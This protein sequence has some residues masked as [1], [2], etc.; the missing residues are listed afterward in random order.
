MNASKMTRKMRQL[1][2]TETKHMLIKKRL[3]NLIWILTL[4]M[5]KVTSKEARIKYYY[6]R[7]TKLVVISDNSYV[8]YIC[9]FL[10]TAFS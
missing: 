8:E 7:P 9:F 1:K 5:L 10:L 3:K 6:S 2:P 4:K